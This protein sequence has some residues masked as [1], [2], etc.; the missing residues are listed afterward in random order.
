[1]RARAEKLGI[2]TI[3]YTED[4]LD[5]EDQALEEAKR[6]AKIKEIEING[7]LE[8]ADEIIARERE[9][10]VRLEK[11][12][13]KQE[14]EDRGRR[15]VA[16]KK[17]QKPKENYEELPSLITEQNLKRYGISGLVL[18]GLIGLILGSAYL[19]RNFPTPVKPT[20]TEENI[21]PTNTN[22]DANVSEP[23]ATTAL[24]VGSTMTSEK[25]GITL[26][27]VPPGKFQ[28][29]SDADDALAECQKFRTDCDRDW[30][31]AEEPVHTVYLD[32]YWID[33]TEV[34]NAMY[35]KCVDAGKCD[36]PNSTKSY[37]RN[38]YYGNSEFGDYPVIYTSWDDATAYCEWADRRL[39][40]EAEWEKAAGWDE[41]YQSPRVYP[42]GDTFDGVKVNFCDTNCNY[43]WKNADYDD[44]YADTSPVGNYPTG[45][46]FYGVYDMAGNVWEWVAD[47]YD[48]NYY[49]NSP[50]SNPTGLLSGEYHVLRGGAWSNLINNLRVSNRAGLNPDDVNL[51][52]F[53]FRCARSP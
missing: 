50:A 11:E 26:V 45:A 25:D 13:E 38:S 3:N 40:T 47:W 12:L 15:K 52:D 18:I 39:P 29:G 16:K 35:A 49:S 1:M 23:T 22:L 42:W 4:K 19:F 53:G 20:P 41:K 37:T 44:G 17:D 21:V 14:S 43:G 34:T 5:K 36:P 32:A 51:Y 9:E 2:P 33:R 31:T 28:M 46:S 48:E 7:I 24:G 8:S 27:Y 10:K 30:F 6:A